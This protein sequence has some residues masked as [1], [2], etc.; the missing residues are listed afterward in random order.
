MRAYWEAGLFL[1]HPSRRGATELIT[2][3]CPL[4]VNYRRT[5]R[6]RS[7]QFRGCIFVLRL[8]ATFWLVWYDMA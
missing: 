7:V 4:A 6:L 3:P 2:Q 8:N 1:R 5:I